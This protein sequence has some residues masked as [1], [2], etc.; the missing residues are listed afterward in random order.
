[1]GET[2]KLRVLIGCERF[3]RVRDAFLA[4]GHDAYSCDL[5]PTVAPG[6]HIQDD[7][8][9]V[10]HFGWDLGI[11]FPDCTHLAV[12]GALRFASKRDL[13]DQAVRFFMQIVEAPIPK[14]AIENPVGIM[15]TRWRRPDQYIQPYQF[16]DDASK[17]TCLWL[18]GLKPLAIDPAKY[19]APRIVDGKP[20]WANQTD[21]G[22][23]RLGPS[24]ERAAIR[25]TTYPGIAQA[26]TQW[27]DT[28]PS[29]P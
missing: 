21:S 19:V 12:S 5:L 17:K 11:F 29:E 24:A 10:M 26:M 15:S 22:Q 8:L 3:G 27:A 23:N 28:R 7:V 6:P 25:G 9:Q 4:L 20:R 1:M 18:K 16:A 2:P 14:I 13:Q